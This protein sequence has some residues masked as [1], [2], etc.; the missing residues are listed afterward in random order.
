VGYRR[1]AASVG[2]VFALPLV[3]ALVLAGCSGDS[4]DGPTGGS[5]A[6]PTDGGAPLDATV[7]GTL[8]DV[9]VD[10]PDAPADLDG[11]AP[12]APDSSDAGPCTIDPTSGEPT[13][14][15]CTGLYSDWPSRTIASNVTAYD[16][17]L[18]LWSDGAVKTRWV[19][20]PPGTTIDTSNMDEWEFPVGTKFWKQFVVNG[21]LTE[22]R[23]LH[24]LGPLSWFY[25]SYYWAPDGSTATQLPTGA[26][27]VNDAG[28]EIPS[29]SK[30]KQCHEG[31]MDFVL[32][33]EA[34]S[35]SSPGATGLPMAT[36]KQKNLLT[37]PP[38]AALTIPGTAVESAALGYL[39]ANCGITCH[40][41]GNGIAGGQTHFFM[42]L[43]AADLGSVAATDTYKTGWN[44]VTT[45]YHAVPDRIAQCSIAKSCIYA[46]MSQRDGIGDAATSTQMPP[47]DTHQIDPTGMATVAAWIDENC[48]DAGP[49]DA[50]ADGH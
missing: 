29:Q 30:C 50:G 42:R 33:F 43:N 5:D 8:A 47:I 45:G 46:R 48:G 23:L 13:E 25:V 41:S 36:L 20:L 3:L 38:V 6:A 31:R 40:N 39:H 21:V 22:T 7:D 35:L 17:G 2:C 32:G 12:D 10:A 34:V 28:Y 9:G 18:H 27:N 14:L 15:R 49:A 19:S 37:A 11:A 1:S 4:S 26:T 44:Q 24:K 16:P